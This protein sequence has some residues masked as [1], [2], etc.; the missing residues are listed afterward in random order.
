[1]GKLEPKTNQPLTDRDRQAFQDLYQQHRQLV[2][3]ICLRMTCDVSES[4]DLTQ[5]VFINLFRTIGSYRGESAFTTW[6]H[7]VTVNH[8]LMYFRK[9]RVRPEL[10]TEIDELTAR[11]VAGSS[12]PKRMK[13]ID[14]I[15]LTEVI[16]Q[17]PKGYHEAVILHDVEGLEH[18]E[19]ARLKG[20]SV[21]T[22]KSQLH[23]ARTMLR[24][25]IT[26]TN[27]PR[28][29]ASSRFLTGSKSKGWPRQRALE[30]A[31]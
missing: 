21:G 1:M 4:E 11:I 6:L 20:R 8:V 22:S 2:Y 28:V 15:L 26:R 24:R 16:G 30:T 9:R 25:L 23:K 7:R 19:I 29:V 5:E 27:R 13:V 3:S 17:L 12:D 31:P 14:R 18:S 10:A